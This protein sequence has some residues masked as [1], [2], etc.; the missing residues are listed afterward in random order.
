GQWHLDVNRVPLERLRLRDR[1]SRL[2]AEDGF[3]VRDPE[4]ATWPAVFYLP[5]PPDS[6]G[7]VELY[8]ET[9]GSVMGG[10]HLAIR[11]QA[12]SDAR[13]AEAR[14]NFRWVYGAL[15]LVAVL[16]LVRHME[17]PDSGAL[18]VGAA[19][20]CSW[21][22]CLGING[23]LY[24]LPEIALLSG[25]GAAVP[26]ALFLLGA[27]PL[28]LATR[29]YA[30]VRRSAPWLAPWTAVL[31]W[32]L[33]AL[34]LYGLFLVQDYQAVGLQWLAMV[35]YALALLACLLMLL[36]DSR[37]YRWAAV[38][39]L[40]AMAVGV[41]A[42]LLADRQVLPAS[43]AS[44]Y[45]W[46]ALLALAMLLYLGL[47]WIRA[48]LKKWAS[49]RRATPPEPSPEEKIELARQR[50]MQSL[51]SGLEHADDD[52]MTWIAYR[53]LLEGLKSV[54]PQLSSA[55]V[56]LQPDGEPLMHVDPPDA[57]PRY[58]ELMTQRTTLVRN[59]SKLKAPQQVGMD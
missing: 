13:E 22:A 17:D 10:L 39:A 43:W 40:L 9:Q 25:R 57:E 5:L 8:L 41:V 58:R 50:L 52:D 49:R 47:P 19:A 26:Q 29:H 18:A 30:G 15:V 12:D 45:G 33:V 36:L 28:V 3:F 56:G 14:R 42:R 54:L 55:V 32:L 11:R 20:F 27:G 51:Q 2:L 59:L 23:H 37:S 16:S 4:I 34:A 7:P 6:A 48:R 53:R 46:Q 24:S 38:L 31:G 44:L 21:L 1:D 35:G